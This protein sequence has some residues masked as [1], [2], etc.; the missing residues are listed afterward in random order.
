MKSANPQSLNCA[1]YMIV[2]AIKVSWL[3]KV[4]TST[5]TMIVEFARLLHT[6]YLLRHFVTL[7]YLIGPC[8]C[9]PL[10]FISPQLLLATVRRRTR[11]WK[12]TDRIIRIEDFN[13]VYYLISP[14]SPSRLLFIRP[15]IWASSYDKG[16]KAGERNS[17]YV[18]MS[19]GG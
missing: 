18:G 9:L 8:C 5:T 14:L 15:T 13:I 6:S 19:R 10:L 3:V 7:P 1:K 11:T 4:I 17:D 16:N 2:P 12:R